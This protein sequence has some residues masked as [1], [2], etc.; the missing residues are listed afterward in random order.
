MLEIIQ[1]IPWTIRFFQ[2]GRNGYCYKWSSKNKIYNLDLHFSTN[3]ARKN[4]SDI[5][6]KQLS[7][8]DIN[9]NRDNWIVLG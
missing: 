8:D 6:E 4:Y 9:S 5:I 1:A 7:L 2:G 3:D